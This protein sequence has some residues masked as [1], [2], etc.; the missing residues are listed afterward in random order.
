MPFYNERFVD[1]SGAEGFG[2]RNGGLCQGMA[3]AQHA[4]E[5]HR[6]HGNHSNIA[7]FLSQRGG[8]LHTNEG[9]TWGFPKIEGSGISYCPITEDQME[10]FMETVSI[11]GFLGL[12]LREGKVRVGECLY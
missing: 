2:V 12:G 3:L 1:C 5:G 7:A 8:H 11:S 4:L 6:F 9:T 10:N